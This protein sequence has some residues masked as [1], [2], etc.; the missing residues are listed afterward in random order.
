MK[1]IKVGKELYIPADNIM[2]LSGCSS[3]ATKNKLKVLKE[4]G[5]IFDYTCGEKRR[6]VIFL[7][8]G[9]A[10]LSSN[11]LETIKQRMESPEDV[12]KGEL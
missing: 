9:D 4:S 12:Q 3:S 6:T 10:V 8:S 1:L 5:R 11:T 7:K 2:L